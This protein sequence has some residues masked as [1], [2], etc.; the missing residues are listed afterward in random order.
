MNRLPRDIAVRTYAVLTF[1]VEIIQM[2]S[3]IL[4]LIN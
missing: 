1:D 2:I 4:D 3:L